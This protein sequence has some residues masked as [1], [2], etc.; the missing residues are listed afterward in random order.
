MKSISTLKRT[1][2]GAKRREKK[3]HDGW[4][5]PTKEESEYQSAREQLW[6]E[7]KACAVGRRQNTLT[8]IYK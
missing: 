2:A 4:K 8:R 6:P 3:R 5:K 7:G 1:Y